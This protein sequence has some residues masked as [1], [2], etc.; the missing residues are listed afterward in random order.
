M[1]RPCLAIVGCA[2][3]V[4]AER[5]DIRAVQ[6]VFARFDLDAEGARRPAFGV[7]LEQLTFDRVVAGHGPYVAGAE[8][9]G[10]QC[11]P[12]LD[13]LEVANLREPAVVGHRRA[14]LQSPAMV[15]DPIE[16][17]VL[18]IERGRARQ[19]RAVADVMCH[20]SCRYGMRY[21]CRSIRPHR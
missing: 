13:Q 11:R 9:V 6:A 20:F 8:H 18:E 15:V 7:H 12:V 16:R 10:A 17:L 21:D 4:R 19:V 5:V 2:A 1:L 3:R 14:S